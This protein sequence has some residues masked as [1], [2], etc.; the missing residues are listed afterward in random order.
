MFSFLCLIL[1]LGDIM[2]YKYMMVNTNG[3]DILYLYLNNQQEFSKDLYYVNHEPVAL[4]KR[5]LHYIQNMGIPFHGSKVNIVV[6]DIVIS[7][8]DLSN[9]D[10]EKDTLIEIIG[11][12]SDYSNKLI[13][14]KES[15][16]LIEQMKVDSYIFGIVARELPSIFHDEALK[17]QA[18]IARTYVMKRLKNN[19]PIKNSDKLGVYQ[20]KRY[21]KDIWGKNYQSY[22]KKIKQ[23]IKETDG[24]ALMFDGDF[25]DAYYHLASNGK[26][27][28][29]SNVLKLAYP[30]LVSVPSEWDTK[31][32]YVSRRIVPND[33]LSKLLNVPISK[34]THFEILMKSIG[35]RVKY[36][37]FGD[38]VFDGF[39]LSRR[40]GLDSNDFSV[41]INDDYTTFTTRGHGHGLGLSEY[42][43]EGMA[44]SGYNYQQILNHYYPNTILTKKRG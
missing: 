37:K 34:N 28:D 33:Y 19:L 12:E 42:G 17:A 4:Y 16:Q 36:V 29:S 43:A 44:R 1:L 40:L 9:Y 14:F 18:V 20:D 5:V 11:V 31:N 7:T 23:A 2:F 3:K 8:I 38:K 30:Y 22:I 27:E 24:E 26:T 41:S 15:G 35:H 39:L 32:E 6:N 10:E 13:D 21:L 25:I